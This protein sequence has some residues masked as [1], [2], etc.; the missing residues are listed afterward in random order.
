MHFFLCLF[1]SSLCQRLWPKREKYGMDTISRVVCNLYP[2]AIFCV[3]DEC[4][5][6][7]CL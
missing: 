2:E 5:C 4:N 6:T 1:K 7:S 3:V